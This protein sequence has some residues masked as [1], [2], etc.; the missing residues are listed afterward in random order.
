M[1]RDMFDFQP[2]T[3]KYSVFIL[4]GLLKAHLADCSA[5][6]NPLSVR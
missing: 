2:P 3:R 4:N 5:Q 1:A 6:L